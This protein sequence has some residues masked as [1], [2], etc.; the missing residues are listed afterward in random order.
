M[1]QQYVKGIGPTN[2]RIAIVGEAPGQEEEASGIPFCGPSGRLLNELLEQAGTR[3]E[4]CY[5]T[6]VSKYRPPGNNIKQLS[7]IGVDIEEQKRNLFEELLSLRKNNLNVILSVGATS[8]EALC[9]EKGITK[10]RGSILTSKI[11]GIKVVPIIH[12]RNILVPRG[13]GGVEYYYK[14][15]TKLDIQ[16]AVR[17]SQF[18]E[19]RTP[20]KMIQIVKSPYQLYKFLEE[21]KKYDIVSLDLETHSSVPICVGLAFNNSHAVSVPLF[22]I[23]TAK[24][25]IDLST[26]DQVEIWQMLSEFLNQE[27]IKFLGQ[28]FKFDH[29]LLIRPLKMIE[30]QPG[31]LHADTSLMMEVAYPELP[32]NQGFMGSLFS[33]EPYYKDEGREFNYKTDRIEQLLIYN[34]K[35]VTVAWDNYLGLLTELEE[36]GMTAFYFEYENKLH[37]FY[38]ELEAEG[39]LRDE[40]AKDKL[41]EHFK[42]EEVLGDSELNE[43]LN[44]SLNVNSPKQVSEAIYGILNL[45]HRD[46][47]GVND[48]VS[49]LGFLKTKTAQDQKYDVG[50]CSR[51]VDLILRQRRIKKTIG[52]YLEIEPDSDGYFRSSYRISS[53]KGDDT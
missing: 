13:S 5:I 34:G 18:K 26:S 31:K 15:I 14:Y 1:N 30:Y 33:E 2:A 46:T 8:M 16:K 36:M 6:N 3:R 12:P 11:D 35:D 32:K 47:V 24:S 42:R 22:S 9:S 37:D 25:R 19:N 51:A 4:E 39:M 20:S 50:K 44:M 17:E 48:L 7:L 21:Y 41:L 29:Q 53:K 38:M 28:N 27:R 23:S 40:E 52:T 43:I 45:P 10:Y 49:L